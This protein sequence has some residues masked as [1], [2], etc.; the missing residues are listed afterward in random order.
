MHSEIRDRDYDRRLTLQQVMAGMLY[1]LCDSCLQ[2]TDVSN[3]LR[4]N[5]FKNRQEG[6]MLKCVSSVFHGEFICLQGPRAGSGSCG[7]C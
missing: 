7:R 5:I 6:A 3:R 4:F 2:F 1:A